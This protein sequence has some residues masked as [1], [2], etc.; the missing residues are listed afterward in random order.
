MNGLFDQCLR[1]SAVLG[2]EHHRPKIAPGSHS[3]STGT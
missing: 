2:H 1:A 3:V